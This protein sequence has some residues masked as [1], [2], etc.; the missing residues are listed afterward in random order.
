MEHYNESHKE[1]IVCV[2]VLG[3][4]QQRNER[5]RKI[6]LRNLNLRAWLQKLTVYRMRLGIEF[7]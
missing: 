1:Q 3:E 6:T 5:V 7:G 4:S 2:Y